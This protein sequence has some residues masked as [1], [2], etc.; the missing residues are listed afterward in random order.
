MR[1]NSHVRFLEGLGTRKGPWPTRR[2][3]GEEQPIKLT[4]FAAILILSESR[5][6]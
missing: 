3:R 4:G 6:R 5:R 2:R 1:G